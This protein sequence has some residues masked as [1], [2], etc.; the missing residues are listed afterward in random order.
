ML[1]AD[2]TARVSALNALKHPWFQINGTN[3]NKL[4]F[5]FDEIEDINVT[6]DEP[7]LFNTMNLQLITTS[8]IW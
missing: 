1:F 8:P 6:D 4:E 5:N 7:C 3:L 2:P